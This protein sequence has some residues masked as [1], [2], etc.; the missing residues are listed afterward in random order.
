M[1]RGKQL[2]SLC[3]FYLSYVATI[4]HLF[5]YWKC[6]PRVNTTFHVGKAWV[7][8]VQCFRLAA[9]PARATADRPGACWSDGGRQMQRN[10]RVPV[11]TTDL[12]RY[13]LEAVVTTHLKEHKWKNLCLW[14]SWPESILLCSLLHLEQRS[15]P[16][17]SSSISETMT[18]LWEVRHPNSFLCMAQAPFA[19]HMS[20]A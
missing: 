9:L 20:V 13:I 10:T 19:A 16:A 1:H 7:L 2:F 4:N 17:R 3:P 6:I 8:H 12:K 5:S 14:L 15:E 18:L 11:D